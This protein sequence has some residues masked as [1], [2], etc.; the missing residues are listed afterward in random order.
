MARHSRTC[1]AGVTALLATFVLGA[2]S[3][4]KEPETTGSAPHLRLI[5]TEQYANT[6]SYL[7]GPSI[8][9]DVKFPPMQRTAGLLS[10]GAGIAGV[11]AS[12]LEQFQRAAAGVALQVVDPAH[13][14]YVIP[15]D[16]VD[17]SKSD[18]ACATKFVTETGRLLQRR[19]LT[20]E[21][22]KFYVEQADAVADRLKDFYAGI[23]MV[24][25][26]MLISPE[27]L[28][29]V[30]APDP[31]W[32]DP[33]NPKRQRLDAYS[34]ASRLSFFLWNAAP[35]DEILQAAESG[36]LYTKKGRARV[37][38]MMLESPRLE[39]GVRAFFD[40]MFGFDEFDSLSKDSTV[41]PF[42]SGQTAA[43]AREQTLRTVVDHL[44]TKNLDYRDLFTTRSTF[45]SPTLAPLYQI[46][47]T[48]GWEPYEFPA[49]S[50]RQGLLTQVSFLAAHAHPGRSS[51]TLRGKALRELMLCQVVP[52]PPTNVSFD[53]IDNPNENYPTQR[54]RVN[55]HLENPACAGCHKITDPTGLALESFDGGGRYRVA[56][57]GHPIDTSG[58]LD[59]TA[60]SDVVGLGKAMR[61]NPGVPRCLVNRLYS[62]GTGSA[63]PP[64]ERPLLEY[65]TERFEKEDYK[66]KDLLRT[67]ALSDAFTA[68]AAVEDAAPQETTPADQVTANLDH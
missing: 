58:D 2:C 13:R 33:E 29:I 40:D 62:Y 10:N 59:G 55:A 60:F 64:A 66:L 68:M 34:L 63:L 50:P 53:L 17:A 44:I 43:D 26:A 24:L 31:E 21:E 42:F 22:I 65:F 28:F 41:Y 39:K 61:D 20:D 7:F 8:S 25:E 5:T 37:V 9:V 3:G 23:G 14:D 32:K 4:A 16:P 35:D 51:P 52:P 19:A 27:M 56:E 49:D 30:E 12:Q 15:C 1:R 11:T 38:D 48:P 57:N 45:M 67:I 18:N 54:D 6:L 46:A 47:T 36:E